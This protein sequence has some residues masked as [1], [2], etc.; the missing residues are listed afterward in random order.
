MFPTYTPLFRRGTFWISDY[1]GF[2]L[3]LLKNTSKYRVFYIYIFDSFNNI[4]IYKRGRYFKTV[5]VNVLKKEA[6]E[7][8]EGIRKVPRHN[9]GVYVGK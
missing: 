7:G 9:R 4:Y 6:T 2:T 5:N 3:R 8:G 1:L